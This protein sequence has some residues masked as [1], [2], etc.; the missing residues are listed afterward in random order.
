MAATI[1]RQ[2]NIEFVHG[3]NTFNMTLEGQA[4][5]TAREAAREAADALGADFG[6]PSFKVNGA[7]VDADYVLYEGDRLEVYKRSGDKG[8]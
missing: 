1:S 4:Q 3:A 2:V 7:A 8:L 6:D 5:Y